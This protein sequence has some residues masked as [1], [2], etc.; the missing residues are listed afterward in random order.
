MM[1][2]QEESTMSGS[3]RPCRAVELPEKSSNA[4]EPLSP[5]KPATMEDQIMENYQLLTTRFRMEREQALEYLYSQAQNEIEQEAIKR[6][7]GVQ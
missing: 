6:V 7:A 1:I 2:M 4:T 3:A 5:I